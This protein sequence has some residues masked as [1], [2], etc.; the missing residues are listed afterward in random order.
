MQQIPN[1]LNA[2]QK[3]FCHW[4][5]LNIHFFRNPAW[6][7]NVFTMCINQYISLCF[8]AVLALA[9]IT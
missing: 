9:H 1:Y 4:F 8:I 2:R 6:C 7:N 5:A 3:L